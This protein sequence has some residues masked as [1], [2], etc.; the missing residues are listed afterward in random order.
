MT[1]AVA[2]LWHR[3]TQARHRWLSPLTRRVLAINV[4]ALAILVGGLLFVGQYRESLFEA[5]VTALLTNGAIIAGAL[6]EGAVEG[7]PEAIALHV[8]IATDFATDG[9]PGSSL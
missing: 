2:R 7:P 6:G 9:N 8:E 5:K 3:A 1:G 4:L